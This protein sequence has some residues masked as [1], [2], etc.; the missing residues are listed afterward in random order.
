[1]TVA[2]AYIRVSGDEQAD[3]GLPVAGQR[4]EI[5]RYARDHGYYLER[6]FVDEARSGGTDDREQFRRMMYEAHRDPAPCEVILLW[7][8]SRFSRDQTDAHYWKAS[9][10]RHGVQIVDV[11]GEVPA[12]EG[13]EY[14]LESLIHWRDEQKRG[15]IA[16]DARRGQ[17][18][19]ARMGYV[20]SGARPP[21]GFVAR[22]ERV[23]IEGR[24]RVARRWVPDPETWPL[25]ERA[26]QMRLRG[27][28][29]KD[30]LRE[31]G[32]Y[33]S[34]GCLNTFFANPIYKGELW[35]GGTVIKTQA[36]VT[37]E[38]WERVNADRGKRRSGA[39]A[40]RQGGDFLLSGL[41]TCARCGSA[42]CAGHSYSHRRNDG[43][44]RSEWRYYLCV[45]RKSRSDCDLPYIDAA[46]LEAAVMEHLFTRIL[47][48]DNLRACSAQIA[49]R[50]NAER[51]AIEARLE[52]ARKKI[53]EITRRVDRLLDAIE[54]APDNAPLVAR[55]RERAAALDAAR[56]EVAELEARLQEPRIAV[57]VDAIRET[58]QEAFRNGSPAE[59]REML[60]GIVENI[61]VDYEEAIVQFKFP[62]GCATQL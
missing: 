25:V 50:R 31:T 52:A 41:L 7:S 6:V 42:L 33:K 32:L 54:D 5:E 18:T 29:Y 62:F 19:L 30:I 28:S 9:L 13:F 12:I 43:Y 24:E 46:K 3:R 10:R 57:D 16:R 55:L 44:E 37:E 38:E 1:M 58:L 40:R 45:G 56:R 53:T 23:T 22:M 34:P 49:E 48:A 4:A 14:V 17:Q 11:S 51:P 60:K 20:P 47:S 61:I 8:W 39:Y 26:W 15:E 36:V 2:W 27:A 59:A 21:R 35:F